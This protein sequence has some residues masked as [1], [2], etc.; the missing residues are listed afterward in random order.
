LDAVLRRAADL[1]AGAL[2]A[3]VVFVAFRAELRLAA[4]LFVVDESG[5]ARRVGGGGSFSPRWASR[6]TTRAVAP[7]P[8][9]TGHSTNPVAPIAASVTAAA[10]VE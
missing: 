4:G 2:V 1:R 7:T 3:L 9:N 5:T 8:T 6:R 10:A